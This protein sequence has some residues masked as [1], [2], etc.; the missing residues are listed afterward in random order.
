MIYLP[1]RFAQL[2]FIGTTHLPDMS[3]CHRYRQQRYHNGNTEIRIFIPYMYADIVFSLTKTIPIK[4]ERVTTHYQTLQTWIGHNTTCHHNFNSLP[5]TLPYIFSQFS[6]VW[7]YFQRVTITSTPYPRVTVHFLTVLHSLA[8]F[9][10][11]YHTLPSN[12]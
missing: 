12:L 2:L 6:L 7:G 4:F 8:L 10:T 3:C 5:H 9:A 11:V 1:K